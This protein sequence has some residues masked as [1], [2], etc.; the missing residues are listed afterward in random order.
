MA[1]NGAADLIDWIADSPPPS[2]NSFPYTATPTSASVRQYVNQTVVP[3]YDVNPASA[4]RASATL[5]TN[6]EGKARFL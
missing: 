2:D 1:A 4:S 5:L 3:A 6:L